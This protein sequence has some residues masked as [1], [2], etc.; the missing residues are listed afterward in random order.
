MPLEIGTRVGAYQVTAKIGEGGMGTVYRAH[1]TTLGREV[2]LKLLSEGLTM[3]P[4]RLTRFRREAKVLASLNH[5]NIGS[6][7]GL[8]STGEAEVFIEPFPGLGL[9]TQVSSEGGQHPVW[10]P[11]GQELY[12]RTFTTGAL[13]SVQVTVEPTLTVGSPAQLG[14]GEYALS[15][16]GQRIYDLFPDGDRFLVFRVVADEPD[17]IHVV[18]NAFKEL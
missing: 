5:P 13:M 18:L 9:K 1:D 15:R 11:D 16:F 6:I 12:Y 10:F 4:D 7:Y 2:A 17:V 8:E 3:D 14:D